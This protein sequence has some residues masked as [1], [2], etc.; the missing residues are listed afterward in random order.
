M[1]NK[2]ME[3][4]INA[5]IHLNNFWEELKKEEKG[6]AEIVA[7]ILVIVI[8]IAVVVIFKDRITETINQVFDKTDTFVN[9]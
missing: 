6:A 2:L 5:Q 3:L 1:D 9:S 4:W 8:I 7:I